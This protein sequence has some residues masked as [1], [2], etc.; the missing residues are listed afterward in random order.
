MFITTLY[1]QA[2]GHFTQKTLDFTP[3]GPSLWIIHG[4]NEAGKSTAL[5]AITDFLFGFGKDTP[6]NFQH[7]NTDLRIGATLRHDHGDSLTAFRRK[8]N[9]DTLLDEQGYPLDA[10]RLQP[11]LGTLDRTRFELLYGLD[12]ERLRKGGEAVLEG[13]GEV[14]ELLFE[15][16]SGIS[17]VR[18]I[19]DQMR[20]EAETFYKP[21][22]KAQIITLQHHRLL[23]VRDRLKQA[24]LPRDQ[25]LQHRQAQERLQKE[26]AT[27]GEHLLEKRRQETKLRQIVTIGP[28]IRRL[29]HL[30]LQQQGHQETPSLGEEIIRERAA[31]TKRRA[32]MDQALEIYQ[33]SLSSLESKLAQLLPEESLIQR[34]SR[35]NALH[36]EGQFVRENAEKLPALEQKLSLLNQK[37]TDLWR[38]AGGQSAIVDEKKIPDKTRLGI[39]RKLM[40]S[41]P[42]LLG[43]MEA[44]HLGI[45]TLHHEALKKQEEIAALGDPI[46]LSPFRQRLAEL[47]LFMQ[48]EREMH[49]AFENSTRASKQAEEKRLLLPLWQ[50]TLEELAACRPPTE[51][52]M[53]RF[54]RDHHQGEDDQRNIT[55][56]L[57]RIRSELAQLQERRQQLQQAFGG[58][59]PTEAAIREAR[60]KRD[61]L[62]QRIRHHWLDD[63]PVAWE[64]D[65]TPGDTFEALMVRSDQLADGRLREAKR[66]AEWQQL[67]VKILGLSQRESHRLEQSRAVT[68]RQE[69]LL[70][71]WRQLWHSLGISQPGTPLEMKGWPTLRS[72]IL[73]LKAEAEDWLQKGNSLHN[74][75]TVAVE[76]VQKIV[77][78][79]GGPAIKPGGNL[80]VTIHQW[81]NFL[82]AC[83]K[84]METRRIAEERLAE[85]A[86]TIQS[87]QEKLEEKQRIVQD[88]DRRWKNLLGQFGHEGGMDV[89]SSGEFLE[90]FSELKDIF[91]Q[92][93]ALLANIQEIIHQRDAFMA[94]LQEL[95]SELGET[96]NTQ[97]P[98]SPFSWLET[99]KV[100]LD[101]AVLENNQRQVHEKQRDEYRELQRHG[102]IT[103]QTDASRM[104]EIEARYGTD[105]PKEMDA[106]EERV[107]LKGEIAKKIIECE[108]E[109]LS[110]AEGRTLA[111][112]LT[113]IQGQEMEKAQETLSQVREEIETLERERRTLD[114]SLGGVT[115]ALDNLTG[116]DEA[117]QMQQELE[118][119]R[120]ELSRH[121]E[122]YIHLHLGTIL[123]QQVISRFQE[124]NQGPVLSRAAEFFRRLT[125]GS[126]NDL[127]IDCV[128]TKTIFYGVRSQGQKVRVEGMSAGT[129]DQ[130]FL[131]LRLAAM[132]VL[133]QG[134]QSIPM[135]LDDILIHFDDHRAAATLNL[136]AGL[137]RQV[138]YFTH[139][140]HILN[141]A[142]EK[143]APGS[144]GVHH[145]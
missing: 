40:E 136:L 115:Q 31:L 122:N 107:R 141:L 45:K 42:K 9:K 14:G 121:A 23:A 69:E 47:P 86:R 102:Q 4:N 24:S 10:N 12:H 100:R 89:E 50:A 118:D 119:T 138:I 26:S 67:E 22:G 98:G 131:A 48:R 82:T 114:Q 46:D 19:M 38:E 117:A 28:M 11:F 143:L 142:Q 116:G 16:G 56:E 55:E 111:A 125:S 120:N 61:Q 65:A 30:R 87:N 57:A 129:R 51:A 36:K 84:Q 60:A 132:E 80:S 130:L 1:L 2:Y 37:Q 133:H 74:A 21:R 68:I 78:S 44:L 35:I 145:L 109:I 96:W 108:G 76:E 123:L 71:S 137:G 90:L 113:E 104:R 17:K 135:I 32:E 91:R 5:A 77:A 140:P 103:R 127:K 8:G 112:L 99:L 88:D 85:I 79:L 105:D 25:W 49:L 134:Q 18:Q 139:H 53:E 101:Q 29:E 92:R 75:L 93:E 63:Q 6:Y 15:A 20:E 72:D 13:K 110:S 126:L 144:F 43:Q 3:H 39:L 54:I 33:S 7:D 64:A 106:V 59:P 95:S 81:Q 62:W 27:N 83:T 124:Q 58:A 128:G 41:R 97:E 94:R 73:R 70:T 34:T 66:L 52:M